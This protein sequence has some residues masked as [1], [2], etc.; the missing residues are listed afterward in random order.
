[1]KYIADNTSGHIGKDTWH[2]LSHKQREVIKRDRANAAK[3]VASFIKE[4]DLR[5]G[6][7]C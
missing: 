1:V 4:K 3:L 7:N 6:K 2:R 5:L